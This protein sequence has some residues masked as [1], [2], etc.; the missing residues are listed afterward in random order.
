MKTS[1][2]LLLIDD[3][4]MFNFLHQT[5]IKQIDSSVEVGIFQMSTNGLA[6]IQRKIR[7]HEILHEVMMIDIRMPEMDGFELME[8]LEKLPKDA[9][10][11][12]KI[13][14]VTSSIDD[15]DR[16][17]AAS[18]PLLSGY[19]EKPISFDKIKEILAY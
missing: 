17:R 7:D 13:Y 10:K 12:T 5:I 19:L 2:Q 8:E 3:D 4:E 15:R 14:F 18:F 11:T 6:E 16:Q 9:F 1:R